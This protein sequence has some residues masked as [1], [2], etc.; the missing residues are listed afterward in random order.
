[1]LGPHG[2]SVN[3]L[4]LEWSLFEQPVFERDLLDIGGSQQDRIGRQ[5]PLQPRTA[6]YDGRHGPYTESGKGTRV[7]LRGHIRGD[8]PKGVGKDVGLG[9]DVD[10]CFYTRG[11]RLIDDV[12]DALRMVDPAIEDLAAIDF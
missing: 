12:P 4:G 3:D 11:Q 7:E 8:S 1:M 10:N 2:N 6:T 9:A 5:E